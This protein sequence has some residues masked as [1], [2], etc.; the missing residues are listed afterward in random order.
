MQLIQSVLKN[1]VKTHSLRW[2]WKHTR[3][4][5]PALA[6]L[7]FLSMIQ[8]YL[9]VTVALG[10]Q[11]VIDAAVSGEAE[12]LL[13]SAL[14]L[15]GML[16]GNLLLSLVSQ[17]GHAKVEADMDRDLKKQMMH[18]IL[19]GNY[20][21]LSVYHSGDL[22]HRLNEDISTV[23][24]VVLSLP[25]QVA[26]L[27]VSTVAVVIVLGKLDKIFTIVLAGICL[28]IGLVTF[29][30]QR[31]LKDI[32]KKVKDMGG[33]VS[34]FLQEV[35][36]RLM[37]V[38]ALEAGETVEKRTDEL[39]E[40][41]WQLMRKR[42][43]LSLLSGMG[44]GI[45]GGGIQFAT[46]I[47]CAAKLL[48]G[49]ITFGVLTSTTQLVGRL[50]APVTML[51]YLLIRL[52][53]MSASAERLME[54]DA[55]RPE[56]RKSDIDVHAIYRDMD[57]IAGEQLCFGYKNEYVLKDVSFEIPKGGLTVI[58]GQSGSGKSTLLKLLMSMYVPDKGKLLLRMKDGKQIELSPDT[59]KM[60]TYAPQGNLLLSG[61]LRDNLLLVKPD[62]DEKEIQE[63]LYASALDE[64]VAQLPQGL[65]T[66]LG[67]N[68]A[69]L[70]EGQ[71]QRLALARALLREAPILL[72]D[73]VTSS[74]DMET[75]RKVLQR[76][77]EYK[78]RTCIVVTHRPAPLKMADL[79]LNVVDGEVFRPG[80]DMGAE[81]LH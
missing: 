67:E 51:P 69:G 35:I 23:Y 74:L 36:E 16:L 2:V 8:S 44:M 17:H 22:T 57:R 80:R 12:N 31:M 45:L 54:I 28:L 66:V 9:G 43:N 20:Q 62:A 21:A 14:L 38:Q 78:D 4:Y 42:K 59:R 52:I 77:R 64:C 68:N 5:T 13:R 58:V 24:G 39:L 32:H 7:I 73:E 76:I 1:R 56:E 11:Q 10:T 19:R 27:A 47:W 50:E 53:N 61:T 25:E 81:Q 15:G 75:E 55:I 37:I 46:L 33:R 72:L 34:G 18:Q 40:E 49:T 29:F 60:F 70:S 6:G 65:D 41:R 26:S 3:K 30:M 79:V 63:V 71:A 48:N